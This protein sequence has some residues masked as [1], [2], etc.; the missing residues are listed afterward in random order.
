MQEVLVRELK[1]V[2]NRAVMENISDGFA[3]INWYDL[4]GALDGNESHPFG[5]LVLLRQ[6]TSARL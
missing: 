6:Q 5:E 1:V 4:P 3:M 2:A